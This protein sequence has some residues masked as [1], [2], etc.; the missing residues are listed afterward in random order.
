LVEIED[1][2]VFN[3][4]I[5]KLHGGTSFEMNREDNAR[6][7][8]VW[9]K[10]SDRLMRSEAH[11]WTSVNYIHHNPVKHGYVRKWQEWPYSSAPWYLLTHGRKWVLERWKAFPLKGYGDKWDSPRA[12]G[13]RACGVPLQRVLQCQ[14]PLKGST[15]SADP[16]KGSTTSAD[17]LKGSIT[18]ERSL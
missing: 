2:K 10:C 11:F 5:G 3:R 14:D 6:G 8:K 15:T 4:L 12:R 1:F 17:P 7:R 13:Q 9:F 16:L 18:S